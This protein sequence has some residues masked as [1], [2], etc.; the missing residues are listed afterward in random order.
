VPPR[1]EYSLTVQ[2]ESLLPILQSMYDWGEGYA[3]KQPVQ[4]V[5]K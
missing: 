2:G 3:A 1:V 5:P 4:T